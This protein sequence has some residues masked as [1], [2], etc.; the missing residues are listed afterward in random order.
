MARVLGFYPNEN[1]PRVNWPLTTDP[2][3]HLKKNNKKYVLFPLRSFPLQI[4]S[5]RR[6]TT[7]MLLKNKLLLN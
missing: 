2:T 6:E 1:D 5:V 7:T 3:R 4:L